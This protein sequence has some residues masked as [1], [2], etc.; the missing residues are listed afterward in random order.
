MIELKKIEWC[1]LKKDGIRI[2]NENERVAEE[3]LSSAESD[4]LEMKK[5]SLK[6][7]NI[8]A[9]YAC[10][11]SFYAILVKIGVKCEIH[12]CSLELLEFL[13]FTNEDKM[14]MKRLKDIRKNVQYYLKKPE[15]VDD[16]SVAGFVLKCKHIFSSLSFDEIKEIRQK[17]E[18]VISGSNKKRSKRSDGDGE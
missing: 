2:I 3:Y 10:Y 17:I 11:N 4:L 13:G 6:W 9:Y 7:K 15:S 1:C 18:N 16:K 14:L 12:D 8:Q 5:S